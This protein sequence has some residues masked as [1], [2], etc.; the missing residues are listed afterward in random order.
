[1]KIW[2]TS[3]QKTHKIRKR[4][5]VSLSGDSVMLIFGC[6]Q[7]AFASA[8]IQPL[9]FC[10]APAGLRVETFT[11]LVLRRDYVVKYGCKN[12]AFVYS[13]VYDS[14][15]LIFLLKQNRS[16]AAKQPIFPAVSVWMDVWLLAST[17]LYGE[18]VAQPQKGWIQTLHF[19][20]PKCKS[21]LLQTESKQLQYIPTPT[22]LILSL[23]EH[24]RM[25]AVISCPQKPPRC[26]CL[27][28]SSL[29]LMACL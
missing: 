8:E 3:L 4:I 10:L 23:K 15:I 22:V 27:S 12:W 6:F 29:R 16:P 20:H 18:Q 5:K 1:M 19:G 24:G 25:W 13:T 17:R 28:C 21:C 2:K 26:P 14:V 9:H 11:E 7:W